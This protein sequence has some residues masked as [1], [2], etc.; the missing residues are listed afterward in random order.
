MAQPEKWRQHF[1]T[2]RYQPSREAFCCSR[3][4]RI[5]LKGAASYDNDVLYRLA[6][7]PMAWKG[8]ELGDRPVVHLTDHDV[9]E[10]IQA[11]QSYARSGLSLHE[12]DSRSFR[13]PSLSQKLEKSKKDLHFNPGMAILRGLRPDPMHQRTDFIIFA[14]IAARLSCGR[15]KQAAGEYIGA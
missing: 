13:L 10:V 3:D 15:G 4:H 8:A 9:V 2:P 11:A 14:G 5:E 6:D 12:V 7:D 1:A